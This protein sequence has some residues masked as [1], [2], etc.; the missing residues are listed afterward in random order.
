MSGCAFLNV[1]KFLRL[2]KCDK[3]GELLFQYFRTR[4]L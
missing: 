3:M 4:K 1:A 2:V